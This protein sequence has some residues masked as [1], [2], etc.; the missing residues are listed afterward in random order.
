M[1]RKTPRQAHEE[2]LG[3]AFWPTPVGE[4]SSARLGSACR[5]GHVLRQVRADF[6]VLHL[7]NLKSPL[8]GSSVSPGTRDGRYPMVPR[9]LSGPS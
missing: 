9:S 7:E 5:L 6:Q 2:A 4:Y 3:A 8:P 1:H